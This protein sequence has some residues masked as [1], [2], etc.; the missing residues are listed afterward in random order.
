MIPG[1]EVDEGRAT[2][3]YRQIAD[4]ILAALRDRRLEPGAK[5][6]PTR[7]LAKTLGVNRNTVVNAYEW[8]A[9]RGLVHSHTGRGTFLTGSAD[10]RE[11]ALDG[12]P[13][14]PRIGAWFT[15][16]SR[17]VEDAG[18]SRLRAIYRTVIA[19]D[20]ISFAGT[21]PAAELL[22][23]EPFR[24]ALDATLGECGAQVLAYGPTQGYPPLREWIAGDM[25]R[26]GADVTPDS[27]LVTN[28]AQQAIDLV[29]RTL[30]DP[31]DPVIV[32]E[33]TYTGALSSLASLGVR[34]IGVPLD[35]QGIRPELL[36]VALERHRPRLVY[37]QP[38]FQN[39]TTAVMGEA[40]R[41]EVLELAAR[42]RC[43]I[44]EDDWA[45]DLD[46]EGR[47]RPTLRSL[48]RDGRVIYLSTFSKK[49]LPG[50]RAGWVAAPPAVLE[51][52]IELK[53]VQDF[54]TSPLI[55]AALHRF[56][57]A[58]EL[59]RHLGR[60]LDVYRARRDAMLA[61]LERCF[62]ATATWT[63]PSGGLFLWLR[64]AP[65][66]HTN[67]LF[68]S[69]RRAGVLFSR[70]ELFHGDGSGGDTMRLAYGGAT[71]DQIESGVS[72]LGRLL[73]ERRS[74]RS[75]EQADAEAVPI[76]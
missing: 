4:G 75:A 5:L 76:L 66:I 44:V 21:Y 26:K 10:E 34:R 51:R 48:D 39:P 17:A 19:S 15:G 50:L 68:V 30:L 25:R 29:F 61:A 53:Q 40:R 22:P 38:T 55:Q 2:P 20:G 35:E 58:G 32:E 63:R 8:L 3:V 46:F 41:Q 73:D 23:I 56:L 9:S 64:L 14:A 52:L 11:P 28:G 27:I 42:H 67:E 6:P 74:E 43:V 47:Q 7:D 37:L 18:M 71:P 65:G 57:D 60:V 12:S 69:A 72:T 62:P 45:D 33:P 31:G 49:L 16:F 70:G 24:R 13:D 59:G 54:G 36:A 1:L